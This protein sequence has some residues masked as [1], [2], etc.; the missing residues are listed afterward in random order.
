[1]AKD[2]SVKVTVSCFLAA[3]L[4]MY[5]FAIFGFFT[6][7]LHKNYLSFLN[8]ADALIITY[9][10]FAVGFIFRPLGS[11][12]FG[13]IGDVY[14]RKRALVLSVTIMGSA[15]LGMFLLPSYAIIGITSCYL[16][17]LLRI[18]QGISVGGEFS[19]ALIYAVE[20]FDGKKAGRVGGVVICGCITGVLV[21]TVVA[22]LLQ[23]PSLPD[24]SWRFAF[25]LGFGLSMLGYFIRKNL[26][27]TPE[28]IKIASNKSKIPLLEG[29]RNYPGQC[30]AATFSAAANGVNFYFILVFLPGYI[31]NIT[32]LKVNFYPLVSTSILI[33]LSPLF[34][35]ISDLISR[36]KL[37]AYGLL[38]LAIYSL[39]GLQLVAAYPS[40]I[41]GLLFFIG[42]A[43]I[44][45]TQAA[46]VNVYIVEMFPTK[47]R[48]SCASFCYSIGIGVIGGT[49]PLMASL[50]VRNFA[51]NAN[52]AISIY[53]SLVCLAGYLSMGAKS[54]SV[55]SRVAAPSF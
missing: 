47:Y 25:L 35:Y 7:I 20:H 49:S 36:T 41:S 34:G 12:I 8:E 37:I 5:D 9:A 21:A 30:V 31:N 15:S 51:E 6:G 32:D 44:F 4:E 46:T 40:F 23:M 54:D 16:I 45:S 33:I 24:Y 17:A 50:I 43:I 26:V 38:V 29:I 2:L 10:L 11:I 52:L 3:C 14:G 19:G 13:Y 1:M 42:H 18:L 28:F 55:N 22:G 27:E 53:M 48:F 39:I